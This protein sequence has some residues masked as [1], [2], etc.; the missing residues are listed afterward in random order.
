MHMFI[1]DQKTHEYMEELLLE[2]Y[3]FFFSCLNSVGSQ[4]VHWDWSDYRCWGQ[5]S[6]VRHPPRCNSAGEAWPQWNWMT[7]FHLE[8]KLQQKWCCMPLLEDHFFSVFC[9]S[10]I[11]S[12]TGND[13][14][15][16][17]GN[18]AAKSS[19]SGH[20]EHMRDFSP[21]DCVSALV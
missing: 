13:S 7:F 12:S 19:V 16:K 5:S 21:C 18:S 1:E 3:L 8:K 11:E 14:L 15:N 17:W 2:I 6:R 9:K 4:C 20:C 10:T